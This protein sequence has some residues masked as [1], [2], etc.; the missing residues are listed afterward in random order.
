MKGSSEV[1]GEIGKI[2]AHHQTAAYVGIVRSVRFLAPDV[3]VLNAAVGM[4]PPGQSDINPPT[5]AI[6]T[7]VAERREGR[8]RAAVFQNT[9]AAF[10]GRPELAE[11]LTEELRQALKEG[12]QNAHAH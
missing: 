1:E 6:Q 5:N 8:W 2:F 7:L 10:H 11:R 9:P 4:V 12:Q 3:A